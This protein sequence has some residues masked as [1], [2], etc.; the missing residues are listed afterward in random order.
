MWEVFSPLLEYNSHGDIRSQFSRFIVTHAWHWQEPTGVSPSPVF[1]FTGRYT[2]CC[3]IW[4]KVEIFLSILQ[5]SGESVFGPFLP[6]GWRWCRWLC[7]AAAAPRCWLVMALLTAWPEAVPNIPSRN[8]GVCT[9][10]PPV[11]DP[12]WMMPQI[13]GYRL[14]FS[15][16]RVYDKIKLGLRLEWNLDGLINCAAIY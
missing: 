14:V 13:L 16:P 3:W 2:S 6:A 8:P 1:G 10:Q 7:C 11:R 12:P 5:I 9:S 4:L 15:S